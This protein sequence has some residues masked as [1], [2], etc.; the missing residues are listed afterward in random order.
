[1][2]FVSVMS[3]CGIGPNSGSTSRTISSHD[4]M[5]AFVARWT[6]GCIGLLVKWDDVPVNC[7][8][9]FAG[10]RRPARRIAGGEACIG[11][12]IDDVALL[13][14]RLCVGGGRFLRHDL[15]HGRLLPLDHRGF[16]A[17]RSSK[18]STIAKWCPE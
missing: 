12:F 1:M 11:G 7:S 16:S 14:L 4:A 9:F 3:N 13:S 2:L 18:L 6:A 5:S 15:S 17:G 10:H 8:S